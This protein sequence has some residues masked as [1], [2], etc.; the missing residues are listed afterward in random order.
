ML[1]QPLDGDLCNSLGAAGAE[2]PAGAAGG[3]G[4]SLMHWISPGSPGHGTARRK[5]SKEHLGL[6]YRD[7]WPPG[8]FRTDPSVVVLVTVRDQHQ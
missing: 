5:G 6:G 3:G 8:A 1:Q 7:F 4:G 2:L